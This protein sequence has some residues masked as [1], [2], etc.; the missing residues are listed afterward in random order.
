M[1]RSLGQYPAAVRMLLALTVLLG[2]A[3]PLTVTGIAL[4]AFGQQANGSPVRIDGRQVGSSLLG[5][6]F[7]DQRG[8]PLPQWFQTRPSA[9]GVT[10]DNPAGYDPTASGASNLGPSNPDLVQ[11]IEQRR[12][13]VADFNGVR[14]EQVPPDAVTASGSGLDPQISPAYAR[15]QVP[16]VAS[17]RGLD[18]AEVR[19]LVEQYTDGR[20]LGFLGEPRVNVLRLNLALA[21][22][23]S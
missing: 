21:R 22:L 11:L 15:L 9:A 18:P 1:T 5:Q 7:A 19:R 6:S 17:A 3:Y 14:P 10:D 4:V 13:R 12:D 16:R 2:L 23:E 20:V 8:D